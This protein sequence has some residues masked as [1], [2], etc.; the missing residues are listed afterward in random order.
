MAPPE[1]K[2]ATVVTPLGQGRRGTR[3]CQRVLTDDGVRPGC[4]V[5]SACE[6]P[7]SLRFV[8]VRGLRVHEIA[9]R[10][11]GVP[12]WA[13]R[14]SSHVRALAPASRGLAR[15]RKARP[16]SLGRTRGGRQAEPAALLLR[17]LRG[18]RSIYMRPRGTHRPW[19][20]S[21]PE[22]KLSQGLVKNCATRQSQ[23]PRKRIFIKISA[24]RNCGSNAEMFCKLRFT[25]PRA[26]ANDPEVR[27]PK[28][29]PIA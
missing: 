6:G 17:Q 8:N 10:R 1:P 24:E 26:H 18:R 25:M 11:A 28:S 12:R 7:Q 5:A 3:A 16:E 21:T 9:P 15:R 22:P 4:G 20:L 23:F 29:R 2:T 27:L 19:L 14:S 13:S